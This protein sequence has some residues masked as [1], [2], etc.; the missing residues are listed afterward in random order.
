MKKNKI[1]TGIFFLI[2]FGIF[3]QN[4]T[5]DIE[6]LSLR[7]K[8][9][10]S[11]IRFSIFDEFLIRDDSSEYVLYSTRINGE[12]IGFIAV[13]DSS[14]FFFQKIENSWMLNDSIPFDTYAFSYKIVDLNGDNNDDFIINSFPDI[15]GQSIPY[16]FICNNM[17]I[18]KYR[19]DIKLHNISFDRN[20][21]QIRS[22]YESCAYCIHTKELYCW[23]N[24]SLKLVER[25]ELDLTKENKI[26]T[27]YYKEINGNLINYKTLKGGS[28]YDTA[29]WKDDF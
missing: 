20:K 17:K 18:L 3:A 1:L 29:L 8:L 22:Y 27:R 24:D 13:T 10:D 2:S 6:N 11:L 7:N 26:S 25:V 15:H 21:K 12:K 28:E 23:E 4:T 5:N 16:V 19:K 14:L 9:L